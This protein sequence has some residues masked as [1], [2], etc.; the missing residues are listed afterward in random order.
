LLP[1]CAR[2]YCWVEEMEFT[3]PPTPSPSLPPNTDGG[4][5][6]APEKPAAASTSGSS[7]FSR[8]KSKVFA[9]GLPNPGKFDDFQREALSATKGDYETFTGLRAEI[10][11]GVSQNFQ[12][13]H[14]LSM[15]DDK[16]GPSYQL[17]TSYVTNSTLLTGRWYTNGL[18]LGR[19]RRELLPGTSL[20][21]MLRAGGER[22][23]NFLQEAS[24][25]HNG[26]DYTAQLT[27]DGRE[28]A[29]MF[30]YAQAITK[31]LALGI[32]TIYHPEQN[33]AIYAGGLRYEND[34]AIVTAVAHSFGRFSATY[35][36]KVSKSVLLSTEF[37]VQ[38]TQEGMESTGV[39]GYEYRL[40][41]NSVKAML[42]SRG[43][44]ASLFEER[45]NEQTSFNLSGMIDYPNQK[46]S[47]GF[48]FALNL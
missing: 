7:F 3:S 29:F 34:K 30:S 15:G 6:S 21:M 8:L 28:E 23:G 19:I 5:A 11:R 42:D 2:W 24:L 48:G 38:P 31:P 4:A 12:V 10:T 40:R 46:Y 35:T 45:Y 9:T 13:G 41:L 47:I 22:K 17:I 36:N 25:D 27:Y 43:R 1:A 16:Q 32:Q 20:S 26:D 44:L 14:M 39:V 37:L 18:L 33:G